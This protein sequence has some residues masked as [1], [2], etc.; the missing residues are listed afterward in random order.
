VAG[1]EGRFTVIQRVYYPVIDLMPEW[2]ATPIRQ[3]PALGEMPPR[4]R[5]RLGESNA[6]YV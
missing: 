3:A 5:L 1:N 4:D 6:F 2:E